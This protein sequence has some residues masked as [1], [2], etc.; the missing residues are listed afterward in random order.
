VSNALSTRPRAG[1]WGG[2]T[3]TGLLLDFIFAGDKNASPKY[4]TATV[5][6]TQ[7]GRAGQPVVTRKAFTNF[8][9]G[10]DGI[11]HKAVFLEA[12]TCM[13]LAIVVHA[14]KTQKSAKLDF[15]CTE[16]RAPD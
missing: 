8:N 3:A 11:E 6:L 1:R 10:P 12:A 5:D 2:D 4:A 14:G 16:A 7:T 9:F 15:Q 13:P